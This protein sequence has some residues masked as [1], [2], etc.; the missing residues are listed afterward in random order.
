MEKLLYRKIQDRE[1]KNYYILSLEMDKSLNFS[2]G[3]EISFDAYSIKTDSTDEVTKD[4]STLILDVTEKIVAKVEKV[5]YS[6]V[7]LHSVGK[8]SFNKCEIYLDTVTL[9]GDGKEVISN[10]ATEYYGNWKVAQY[11]LKGTEKVYLK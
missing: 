8:F 7:D 3:D 9:D 6:L 2:V 10:H 4:K 11:S 5:Q 1:G